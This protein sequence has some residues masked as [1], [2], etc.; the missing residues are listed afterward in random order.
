MRTPGATQ[1]ESTQEIGLSTSL[2]YDPRAA[3]AALSYRAHLAKWGIRPVRSVEEA[4]EGQSTGTFEDYLMVAER[5]VDDQEFYEWMSDRRRLGA[6]HSTKWAEILTS[7]VWAQL[8]LS[9]LCPTGTVLDAGCNA[10][11]WTTW[12][13]GQREAEVVGVDRVE[14]A[15]RLGRE[16]I[17]ATRLRG[18]LELAEYE[19]ADRL[20]QFDAVVS[21]QGISRY[22]TRGD[23][24][25]L[26]ALIPRVAADGL[27]IL[28]DRP[29][30]PETL[31]EFGATL[32]SAD[33]GL[34]GVGCIGGLTLDDWKCLPGYVFRRGHRSAIAIAE[35]ETLSDTMW[36]DHFRA[37][38]NRDIEGDWTR[39]NTAYHWADGG[40][41]LH[42]VD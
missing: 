36:R 27:L 2:R 33:L 7:G 22:L 17:T 24:G 12:A 11:Y 34:V 3:T 25:P 31:E 41:F 38:A 9:D 42:F 40:P 10:G 20:G 5:P 19:D 39:R 35:A 6:V 37:F 29:A 4:F 14:S 13:A 15:V 16:R 8:V 32:Q 26:R 30:S 1:P 23:F 28:V 18:R 21:L